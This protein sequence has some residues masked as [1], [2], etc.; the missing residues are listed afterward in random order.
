MGNFGLTNPWLKFGVGLLLLGIALAA[1]PFLFETGGLGLV[2]TTTGL[3]VFLAGAVLYVGG[4][5]A[6]AVQ[7]LTGRSGVEG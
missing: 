7:G 6:K 3:S 1:W 2:L 4:R 5:I